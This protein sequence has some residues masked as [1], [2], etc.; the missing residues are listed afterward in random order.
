M[1]G[2][3]MFLVRCLR[4]TFVAQDAIFFPV[5]KP[6]NILRGAF[7]ILFRDLAC[8]CAADDH[9]ADCPY[10][11]IFAP[12]PRIP[13]PS[14]FADLPRPFVFRAAHLDGLR[15]A[16][17]E[18]FHFDVNLFMRDDWPV[19]YFEAAFAKLA[20]E[21][22]GPGRGRAV[23]AGF[24]QAVQEVS[25]DPPAVRVDRLTVQFVTPTE[26][27]AAEGLWAEPRFEV[28]VARLRDRISNLRAQYGD[29]PL[30]IDYLGLAERARR[31]ELLQ[32][33]LQH[34]D[35][36][37][38]SSR[39]GQRHPLS[40]FIGEATYSGELTEFLPYLEI[41]QYTGVGRQTVW[42]KGEFRVVRP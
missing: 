29:G 5:H 19:A 13:G 12:K 11:Q 42:G 4:L 8:R 34:V 18:E 1:T 26:L 17:G 6:G 33:D 2:R 10:A 32:A 25:L 16:P 37:R 40:G 28:L 35:V 15:I 20:G 23:L 31:V 7:G 21:G 9:S 27:K 30:A 3:G 39:T 14:G 38:R 41:G 22:L 24:A 36:E